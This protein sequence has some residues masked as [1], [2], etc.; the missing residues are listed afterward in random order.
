MSK[1]RRRSTI[2]CR[3]TRAAASALL[4]FEGEDTNMAKKVADVLREML[5]LSGRMDELIHTLERN[6]A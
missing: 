6:T 5:V 3:Y 4:A 2:G 1:R